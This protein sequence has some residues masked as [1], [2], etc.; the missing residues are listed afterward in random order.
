MSKDNIKFGGKEVHSKEQSL[1]DQNS[2]SKHSS[3]ASEKATLLFCLI[4]RAVTRDKMMT[5]HQNKELSRITYH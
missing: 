1:K 4:W 2:L 3:F 5:K